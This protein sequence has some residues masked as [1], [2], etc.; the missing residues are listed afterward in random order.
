MSACVLHATRIIRD[1]SVALPIDIPVPQSTRLSVVLRR[2]HYDVKVVLREAAEPNP[3]QPNPIQ[4]AV[5]NEP[6]HCSRTV[7]KQTTFLGARPCGCVP[8]AAV[9]LLH[10]QFEQGSRKFRQELGRAIQAQSKVDPDTDAF[11]EAVE[12]AM[13]TL[14]DE[15]LDEPVGDTPEDARGVHVLEA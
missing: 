14:P 11:R 13:A 6:T 3:T 9:S 4:E 8:A 12:Q 10:H 1:I 2:I 7:H 15:A 5:K